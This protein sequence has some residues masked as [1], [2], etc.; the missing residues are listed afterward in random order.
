MIE[1]PSAPRSHTRLR[2]TFLSGLVVLLVAASPLLGGKKNPMSFAAEMAKEG[3][4]REARYRWEQ[5]LR[6]QPGNPR[7]LNNLAVASE[8]LGEIAD[9]NRY[10]K[11]SLRSVRDDRVIDNQRRFERARELFRPG[12]AV[13]ADDAE[14]ALDP[15]PAGKS[16]K[17]SKNAKTSRVTVAL[18]VPPKIDVADFESI[19]VASFLTNDSVL[20]NI[21]R[22]LVRLL[23]GEFRQATSLDVADIVPPPAIPEQS[24]EDLLAN[25]DFWQ[26][27]A[28][29]YE[30][31]LIVSGTVN[32]E[33][34]DTSGFQD[35]DIVDNTTG[36]RIRDSR[37]V[38]QEDFVYALEVFFIEGS[39]GDLLFRDRVRR[40]IRFKGT[41]NDPMGAFYEMS[42]TI[43]HDVLAVVTTRVRT[44][45]RII[46]KG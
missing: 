5:V 27:L 30:V 33:Q 31:D 28:R 16:D 1:R 23:R 8:A 46:F 12:E 9:A 32:Y 42:E 19:L 18:P 14:P 4:W 7:V 13:E 26:Y 29:E 10:Y 45:T 43:A 25:K 15:A 41:S 34:E 11:E 38:E 22:E 44:D 21:N 36:Q 40:S 24:V 6:E 20:M 17:K 3:N 35:V 2:G 39:S 37:Y